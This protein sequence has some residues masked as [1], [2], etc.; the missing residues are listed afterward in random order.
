MSD[1]HT[2]FLEALAQRSHYKI[3]Q[4]LRAADDIWNDGGDAVDECKRDAGVNHLKKKIWTLY[5]LL[6]NQLHREG[7]EAIYLEAVEPDLDILADEI[8][9]EIMDDIVTAI[10]E[11]VEEIS[12]QSFIALFE[13]TYRKNLRLL[14]QRASRELNG[15]EDELQESMFSGSNLAELKRLLLDFSMYPNCFALA[16]YKTEET[17]TEFYKGSIVA[18]LKESYSFRRINPWNVFPC[19]SRSSIEGCTDYFIIEDYCEEALKK[20]K[21]KKGTNTSVLNDVLNKA[22]DYNVGWYTTNCRDF[23]SLSMKDIPVVKFIGT[24]EDGSYGEIWS[25]AGKEI[26]KSEGKADAAI[27]ISASYR[28]NNDSIWGTGLVDIGWRLQKVLDEL[29]RMMVQNIGHRAKPGGTVPVSLFKELLKNSDKT[30]GQPTI[31]YETVTPIPDDMWLRGYSVR[32][33]DVPDRTQ[34]IQITMD[35]IKREIDSLLGIPG[36]A[37]GSQNVGT[38][39]R[40]YQGMFLLQSN[41]MLSIRSVWSHF[42]ENILVR[43]A[44][45]VING[46]LLLKDGI[47]APTL[48]F[49]IR[50]RPFYMQDEDLEDADALIKR[51]Q[52]I[53]ALRDAGLVPPQAEQP[54]A[55]EALE[56]LGVD[57]NNLPNAEIDELQQPQQQV[58]VEQTPVSN[59]FE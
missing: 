58:P 44:Q 3:D 45:R 20:L 14:L 59:V 27:V 9:E 4:R 46:K 26:Y 35:V 52:A 19:E 41:M 12:F 17:K 2:R 25:V 21:G 24:M 49:S 43:I 56:K 15:L 1:Y 50:V 30:T 23:P 51:I 6:I 47:D 32:Q 33:F 11:G 36:F 48:D 16:A 22:A 34:Q 39:G 57:L 5:S 10:Q 55:E 40:S 42:S 28:P 7:E 8:A 29:S 13:Q 38:V 31:S 18:K 54:L 53:V 37:D